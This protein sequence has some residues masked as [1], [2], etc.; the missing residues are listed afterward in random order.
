MR[1]TAKCPFCQYVT[2]GSRTWRRRY[3]AQHLFET[4]W[5]AL[6]KEV[7]KLNPKYLKRKLK[8]LDD[9]GGQGFTVDWPDPSKLPKECIEKTEEISNHI[10]K[11]AVKFDVAF[12]YMGLLGI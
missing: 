1:P 4:H 8:E 3:L 6:L 11:L 12:W 5:D 2:H 10:Y 9:K 7:E